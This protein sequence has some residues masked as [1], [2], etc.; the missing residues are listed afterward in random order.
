MT[1]PPPGGA[2]DFSS[3]KLCIATSYPTSMYRLTKAIY[4]DPLGTGPGDSRFG[5][6]RYHRGLPNPFQIMYLGP[7]YETCFLETIVRDLGSAA[8]PGA[9]PIEESDLLQWN[10][11]QISLPNDL[12]LLDLSGGN[13]I[14]MRIP[15]DVA[16]ASDH[17]LGMEWSRRFYDHPDEI[18]GL[19]FRSRLNEQFNVAIYDRSIFDLSVISTDP[20]MDD[21][22]ELGR[23][24]DKYDLAFISA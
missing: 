21:V 14:T 4:P 19:I 17:T 12:K 5:D 18:D 3:Q 22:F 11:S 10:I 2:V 20:L 23:V 13:L 24:L 8:G 16:R 7:D 9:L 1:V 6:I 15:T